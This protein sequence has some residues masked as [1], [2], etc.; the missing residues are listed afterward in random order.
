MGK[1]EEGFSGT[2]IKDTWTQPRRSGIE[3]GGGG[4]WGE[5]GVVGGKW[6]HLSL[7]NNTQKFKKRR[8]L[9]DWSR[10]RNRCDEQKRVCVWLRNQGRKHV[11]LR[12]IKMKI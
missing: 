4:G 11:E 7:N 6:R 9:R 1:R 5:R 12:L 3:V 10:V 2:T 8:T